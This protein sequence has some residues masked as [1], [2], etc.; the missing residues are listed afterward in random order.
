MPNK[1]IPP[2]DLLF[3]LLE[4][5]GSP[6]H[7]GAVQIFQKPPGAPTDYLLELVKAFKAA[8]VAPPFNYRPRFP[9]FGLPEWEVDEGLDI[10]YHVR[11]SALPR[12]GNDDQLVEVLQRLHGGVLSRDRPGWI[13]QVIEG[14][15]GDRFAIYSKVHHAYIDGMSGVKRMYRVLSPSPD[16]S[17]IVP[18][19]SFQAEARRETTREPVDVLGSIARGLGT[20]LRALGEVAGA[21]GRMGSQFVQASPRGAQPLFHAPRTRMNSPVEYDTRAIAFCSLPLDRVRAVAERTG[22]KVN[23]VVLSVVDAALHDYLEQRGE[24]TR[25]PLV[26][27][28]PMSTREEGDDSA[29]TQASALHVRLGAPGADPRLRLDQV[30]AAARA[31]K[32]EARSLSREALLDFALV[33]AGALELADRTPLGRFLAPSYNVLVSNVPGP[34][35]DPLYLC[36]ARQLAS[37]PI[38]AFLPGGNLNITLLSH[39]NRI[40]FGLVADK[41]ALPDVAEVARG[42]ERHFELLEAAV[43]GRKRPGTASGKS[44]SKTGRARR[45]A[46]GQES[47]RRTG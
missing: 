18:T 11:H 32:S 35:E 16:D 45:K 15:E 13:S 4:T 19:W 21:L 30:A 9:R 42:I 43:P 7:V 38:S 6:K 33:T 46:R 40:D 8:P 2:L 37:F 5:P 26:A 10:D 22:T 23:D 14:L 28:C 44:R 31:A 29:T 34:R 20:Q 25:N 24:N 17:A 3:F 36:G 41:H 47:R 27:L 39:G 12:P 1:K